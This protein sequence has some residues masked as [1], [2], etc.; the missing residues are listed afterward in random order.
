MAVGIFCFLRV[1]SKYDKIGTRRSSYRDRGSEGLD[2]RSASL[3]SDW[4]VAPFVGSSVG[5]SLSF[6]SLQYVE[7]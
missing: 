6:G 7:D 1:R 3:V 2:W 5:D 4:R